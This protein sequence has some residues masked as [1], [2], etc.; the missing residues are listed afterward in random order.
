MMALLS[1]ERYS[2]PSKTSKMELFTKK[3]NGLKPLSIS[4][5]SSILDV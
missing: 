3:L 4:T 1:A 5:K 2:E